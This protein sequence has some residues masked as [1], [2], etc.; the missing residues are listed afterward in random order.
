MVGI[1]HFRRKVVDTFGN[2]LLSQSSW[3]L[4]SSLGTMPR[5]LQLP[6]YC[7]K[8]ELLKTSS[9]AGA[10]EPDCTESVNWQMKDAEWWYECVLGK[11]R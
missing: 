3:F 2:T 4:S 1:L 5:K 11:V 8:L 9:Q 6:G 7:K 10:W